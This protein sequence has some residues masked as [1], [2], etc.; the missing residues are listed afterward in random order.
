M[1]KAV[2]AGAIA[3]L[4]ASVAMKLS[5]QLWQKVYDEPSYEDDMT[6]RIAGK[7][8]AA[9]HLA[10]GT[11]LGIGYSVAVELF[12]HTAKAAGIP[13]FVSEAVLGNELIGPKL[14]LFKPPSEYPSS[15]HWNSVITHMV[16]G[17]V[18]ELVRREV[19]ERL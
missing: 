9:A 8:A 18:A 14:G 3:G 12:P 7:H 11:A 16:Y 4:A 10:I 19:R 6:E 13:F 2:I 17:A 5:D 1:K 15:K